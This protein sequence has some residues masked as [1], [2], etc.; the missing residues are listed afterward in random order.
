MEFEM[1]SLEDRGEDFEKK[2][3]HDEEL[4]FKAEARRNRL[5]AEWAAERLGISPQTNIDAYIDDVVTA[6]LAEAGSEDVLRKVRSDFASRGVDLDESVLTTKLNE[7]MSLA[8]QQ[9][10]EE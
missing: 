2:F 4:R 8:V 5:L 6:D 1:S 9:I 7:F 10:Q 3:A